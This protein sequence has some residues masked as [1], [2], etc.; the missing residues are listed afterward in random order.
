MQILPLSGSA[1]A[2]GEEPRNL[3]A[4]DTPVTVVDVDPAAPTRSDDVAPLRRGLASWDPGLGRQ[5]SDAQQALDF[6]DQAASQLRG[7]KTELSAKLSRRG[8]QDG[9]LEARLRQFVDTW[10]QRPSASAGSLSPQLD[11]S[12]PTPAAQRF[13][14]RGL[15]LKALQS[16][17]K[18]TLA[19]SVGGT[20]QGPTS[21]NIDPSMSEDAI[22]AQ[23]QR[24]L[25][26]G[27]IAVTADDSGALQFSVPETAW[28]SVRDT[29]SIKGGG[30]RFPAGQ[31]NRVKIDA[32]PA[33]IQP[34]G[35]RAD[36]DS[37]TRQS[38]REVV[39]ALDRL[40]QARDVVSRA[41]A[42][43]S[44]RIEQSAPSDNATSAATLAKGVASALDQPGYLAFSSITGAL[45][46]ISRDRVLSLLSL[47]LT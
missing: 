24:A 21:V 30:I 25:A 27:G 11:Y 5:L 47:R 1:V 31:F 23:L 2:A 8:V 40:R 41:L 43:A 46:G 29:L 39:Q 14:I 13:T 9:Q 6:L 19:I 16:G 15:N 3:E 33:A 28:K 18:E 22:V 38:L 7:L 32:E 35:W 37:A 10:R 34:E 44:V 36:D 42:A 4:V 20:G 12:S 17:D 26:P 45:M